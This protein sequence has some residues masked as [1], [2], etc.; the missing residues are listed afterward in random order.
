MCCGDMSLESAVVDR[1]GNLQHAVNGWSAT[2][3][4]KVWDE[5]FE[6]TERINSLEGGEE[7]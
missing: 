3:E 6:L 2:H 4:C 7:K 5:V 1:D